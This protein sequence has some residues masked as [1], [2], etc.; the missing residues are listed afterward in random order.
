MI[1]ASTGLSDSARSTVSTTAW[2]ISSAVA[3][4]AGTKST[5]QAETCGSAR[6]CGIA[7]A[8]VAAVAL[9][10]MSTGFATL[11]SAGSTARRPATA[12]SPS[13]GSSRPAA[14]H[15]SAQRIPRPPA[16]VTIPT[17][18]PSSRPP[19][20]NS[21]ATSTSSSSVSARITPA[22]R[23]R[24]SAAASEPARAAVCELAARW[25]LC[26]RPLLRARIGLRRATLRAMRANRRGFPND[27]T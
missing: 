17:E 20:E 5:M 12:S 23:K 8:Y 26:E 4:T 22:C 1:T 2:A 18:R 13:A 24:A 9:P 25:P 7:A 11:A 14:S 16:F 10:S 21:E 15:A 6:T 3:V 27:S 19:A